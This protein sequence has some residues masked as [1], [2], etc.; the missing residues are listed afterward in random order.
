MWGLDK[1]PRIP[2]ILILIPRIIGLLKNNKII[3]S[4]AGRK[5]DGK[6]GKPG[7]HQTGKLY[8]YVEE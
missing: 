8:V 2:G 1:H 3:F 5:A 6:P 4:K 7:K